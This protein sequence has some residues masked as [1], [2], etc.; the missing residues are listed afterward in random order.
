[1]D[2]KRLSL[3]D[4]QLNLAV[5]TQIPFSKL[6]GKDSE[7]S[8]LCADGLVYSDTVLDSQKQCMQGIIA[9]CNVVML[10]IQRAC[11]PRKYRHLLLRRRYR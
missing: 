10:F 11:K 4:F 3:E 1:M 5:A 2:A 8:N 6:F 9:R 7:W